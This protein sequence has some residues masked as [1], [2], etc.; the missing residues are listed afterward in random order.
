MVPI[1]SPLPPKLLPLLPTGRAQPPVSVGCLVIESAGP[2]GTD[3]GGRRGRRG[4]EGNDGQQSTT[5]TTRLLLM[6]SGSGFSENS[7]N[8]RGMYGASC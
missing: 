2:R 8:G 5:T 6:D 1:P 3:H 4:L 7:K